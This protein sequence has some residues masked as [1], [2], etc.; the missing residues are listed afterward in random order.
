MSDIFD[1]LDEI[2]EAA[3]K[4]ATLENASFGFPND[5]VE[6][7]SVHFGDD[8]TGRVGDVLHPDEYVKRLVKLHHGSWIIGPIR[9]ARALL[10]LHKETL[11]AV[12]ALRKEIKRSELLKIS[13]RIADAASAGRGI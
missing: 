12:E 13:E 6:I 1:R 8:R 11:D 7:K 9:E 2:L 5:R 10:T 3:E 4:S